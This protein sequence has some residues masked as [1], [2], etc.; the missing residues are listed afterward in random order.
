MT[1]YGC[2]ADLIEPSGPKVRC[3]AEVKV[4]GGRLEKLVHD[5]AVE[6]TGIDRDALLELADEMEDDAGWCDSISEKHTVWA[7]T[8]RGYSDRIRKALGVES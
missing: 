6:L 2:L 7:G 5:V 1:P 4:D 3:V 8:I